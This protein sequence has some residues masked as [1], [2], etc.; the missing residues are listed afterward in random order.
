MSSDAATDPRSDM[1]DFPRLG[2][3]ST[4]FRDE[5][6]A[7]WAA[8]ETLLARIER[9]G[10]R[11]LSDD[12]LLRL[13]GLYR[14]VLSSLSVARATSLDQSV[15]AYLESLS[16]RAYYSL[17]G[18]RPPVWQRFLHYMRTGWPE[19][20]RAIWPELLVSFGILFLATILSMSFVMSDPEWFYAFVDAGLAGDRTPAATREQLLDVIYT[21]PD[22]ASG[23]GIFA[24]A[25]F[26]HN[27]GVAILA[28]ALGFA[29]GIPTLFLLIQNGL[30]LGAFLGL[31][32][33]KGLGY[34]IGGWLTVHGTTEI[35]AIVLAGAG[36]LHIGRAVAFPGHLSRLKSVAN[37]G[38]VGGRVLGGVVIMLF[39]AGL[40][41]AYPRQLVSSDEIRYLIGLSLL[42]LWFAYFFMPRG[43]GE[44]TS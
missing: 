27:S 35:F 20:V 43:R 6:Q 15:I 31:H 34:E 37:A 19:A 22:E 21:D 18:T 25:L 10:T 28:F 32:I 16:E 33:N 30:M 38:D 5:R 11:R 3:R 2:L 41:E 9:S 24:T 40:L 23:L 17:Y 36:G 13:P 7:D 12:D 14:S 29:F 42:V 4:R 39:V 26:S 8:L 1:S 44:V